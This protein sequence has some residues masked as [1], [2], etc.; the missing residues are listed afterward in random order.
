MVDTLRRAKSFVIV[1]THYQNQTM[2]RIAYNSARKST[3][4]SL[5][6][7]SRPLMNRNTLL[8][9]RTTNT[10]VCS[11]STLSR[12]QK[13]SLVGVADES[14]NAIKPYGQRLRFLSSSSASSA[15]EGMLLLFLH[16]YNLSC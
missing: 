7:I 14:R 9:S 2:Q 10:A 16:H 12:M 3:P 11:L 15:A 5:V 4:S 6:N 13:I 8:L 1:L